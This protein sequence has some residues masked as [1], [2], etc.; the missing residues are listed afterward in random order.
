M[1][2]SK[3]CHFVIKWCSGGSFGLSATILSAEINW[4]RPNKPSINPR[5][6]T[7]PR[8]SRGLADKIARPL[9]SRIAYC[10]LL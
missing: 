9:R 4:L 2:L 6:P 1:G 5:G 7:R 10:V 8:R 3:G